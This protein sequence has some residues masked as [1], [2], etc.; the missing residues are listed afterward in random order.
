MIIVKLFLS[1]CITAA[2]WLLYGAPN[3]EMSG[4]LIVFSVTVIHLLI[5]V[6]NKEIFDLL[7]GDSFTYGMA[8][9]G[10]NLASFGWTLVSGF[11]ILKIY[12][13]KIEDYEQ[14]PYYVW[15]V[16]LLGLIISLAIQLLS[17]KYV[18]PLPR[19]TDRREYENTSWKE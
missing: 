2:F 4:N 3:L 5:I 18:T 9:L 19:S 17:N 15:G 8:T 14:V 10:I 16:M 6:W 12:G 1:L 7:Q 11:V 13:Y